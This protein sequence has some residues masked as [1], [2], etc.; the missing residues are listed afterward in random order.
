AVVLHQPGQRAGGEP[1]DDAERRSLDLGLDLARRIRPRH[2][3][4][5]V[6][7]EFEVGD[8]GVQYRGVMIAIAFVQFLH[9]LDA[10]REEA[11][12]AQRGARR[13]ARRREVDV[14]GERGGTVNGRTGAPVFTSGE[15][16]CTRTAG[17]GGTVQE[18]NAPGDGRT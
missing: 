11:R 15:R 8:L 18:M 10:G 16:Y 14:A 1:P 6:E 9:A 4:R 12:V 17:P 3:D 2:L 5:D 13:R 7:L